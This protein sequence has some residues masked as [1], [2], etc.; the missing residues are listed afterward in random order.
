LAEDL[1]KARIATYSYVSD[2][3]SQNPSFLVRN[4]LYGRALDLVKELGALRQRDGTMR[5]PVVFLAHSLGGLIL[6][7]SLIISSE[8]TELNLR[9]IELSTCGVVFFGTPSTTATGVR[10]P[11]ASVIRRTSSLM[12]SAKT[13]EENVGRSKSKRSTKTRSSGSPE[14]D[15]RDVEWL[16]SQM[17]AFKAIKSGLPILSFHET[18]QSKEGG[19]VSGLRLIQERDHH[20]AQQYRLPC[21][22]SSLLGRLLTIIFAGSG[23]TG[24][25]ARL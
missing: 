15:P 10:S 16:E 18:K 6:R 17:E 20:I 21:R 1:P 23:K 22:Y 3:A 19:F 25:C 24:V 7:R 8:A 5:R 9:E 2:A 4:V 12:E 11:L 14:P 13:S